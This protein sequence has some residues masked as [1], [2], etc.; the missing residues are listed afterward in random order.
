MKKTKAFI[1]YSSVY[2]LH[3]LVHVAKKKSQNSLQE[4]KQL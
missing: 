3:A 2:A 1:F 4:I